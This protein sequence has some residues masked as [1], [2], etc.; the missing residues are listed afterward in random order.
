MEDGIA[1]SKKDVR[2]KMNRKTFS[3]HLV[4]RRKEG[5][6]QVMQLEPENELQAFIK[7]QNKC[8][9][10]EVRQEPIIRRQAWDTFFLA[11]RSK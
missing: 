2:K 10:S 4:G 8:L 7:L 11:P 1:L 5:L 9:E 6:Y 3:E